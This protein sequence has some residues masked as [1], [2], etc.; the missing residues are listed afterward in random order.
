MGGIHSDPQIEYPIVAGNV[1]VIF[2]ASPFLMRVLKY[3][4]RC[5]AL[6][7]VLALI[8][9]Q[10][11]LAQELG[12]TTIGPS[13]PLS[14]APAHQGHPND[15]SSEPSPNELP[16]QSESYARPAPSAPAPRAA[17][18]TAPT[19]GSVTDSTQSPAASGSEEKPEVPAKQHKFF[20]Y[21]V[22]SGD[23]LSTLA[24][25]FGISKTDLAKLNKIH[26]DDVLNVGQ[27]LKIP[28]PFEAAQR[29]LET[30]VDLL[31]DESRATQQKLQQAEEQVLSL[32][33]SNS[34]LTADNASLK[35]SV[36][37]MPWW[38]G[39]A[40]G[41]GAAALLMLGVTA[42]T[43]FEWWM[44]R[45]RFLALS[46]LSMSLSRLDVK[47][48]ETMAKAEL[49]MQQ[50]YGRRRPAASP[51][52]LLGGTKTPDEIEVERLSNEL[53]E[54][55]ERHLEQLGIR[56]RRTIGARWREALGGEKEPAAEPRPY[57][58]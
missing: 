46:D 22:R 38:R 15:A 14:P 52:N 1:A 12:E 23:T 56:G 9:A 8:G 48:K 33:S 2:G 50:L 26:E 36:K 16:A 39:M 5:A 19:D 17:E 30:Q 6:V 21:S 42:L 40:L 24:T 11:T 7:C 45:R 35:E 37:I 57:R 13:A 54:T 32:S 41:V 29:N 34:Q 49:R 27:L 10:L 3:S 51:D 43:L 53:R 44:L 47:Y 55:L 18:E 25:Y 58:R 4:A 20:P 31:S 28:N